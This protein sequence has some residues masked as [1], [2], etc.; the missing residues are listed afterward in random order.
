VSGA[1]TA[2]LLLYHRRLGILSA[3]TGVVL[4]FAGV[5]IGGHYPQDVIGGFALGALVV[6]IGWVIVRIP[7]TTLI[8]QLT[9]TPLRPLLMARSR[10]VLAGGAEGG[11]DGHDTYGARPG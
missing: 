6:L 9:A 2:G 3:F 11:A 8:R 7:L 1:V 10:P 5:Y 4:C